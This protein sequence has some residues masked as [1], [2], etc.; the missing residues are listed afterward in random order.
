MTSIIANSGG[1]T[2]ARSAEKND[3]ASS[4]DDERVDGDV[5][6]K[7][8]R[9]RQEAS[10]LVSNA[11]EQRHN[12]VGAHAMFR[13]VS[14]R[15]ERNPDYALAMVESSSPVL[16]SVVEGV[17]LRMRVDKLEG[18]LQA[19]QNILQ[20]L[21][22]H[23]PAQYRDSGTLGLDQSQYPGTVQSTSAMQSPNSSKNNGIS[24]Q[25]NILAASQQ[26]APQ[27]FASYEPESEPS[28]SNESYT[29]SNLPVESSGSDPT[30]AVGAALLHPEESMQEFPPWDLLYSLA[31]LF[32]K[33]INTW[34]PILHR[35]STLD[36]LF[37]SQALDEADRM[38]LH[39]IV[40]TTL[41][42]STDTRVDEDARKRYHDLSK[43][44]V[45]L[46][47]L[48]NSSVKAL[49]ALVILALDIV[50]NSNGPPGW[51]LLALITRSVV[52][53]GLAVETTSAS[54]APLYPSIYTLRAMVLPEPES[55]IE[56]EGRR[57]LFWTVYMLDRYATISTA[58]EFALDDREIDRKLP[59]R[60]DLLSANEAVTTRW[61]Q[62]AG[63]TGLDVDDVKNVG[64]FGYYI[65]ILGIMSHIHRFLKK[66]V[67][68]GALSDVEEWQAEYRQ[69]DH[70][71]SNWK[72][73]LPSDQGNMSRI[74]SSNGSEK[75]ITPLWIMLHITYQTA[76]IR[77]HS[78]AAYPTT[79]SPIF[80]PSFSAAQKCQSAV[81]DIRALSTYV[82]ASNLL[83]QL[84]PPFAFSL[85][86][87]AR[88]LLV[89]SST[90]DHAVSPAIAPLVAILKQMGHYWNVAARYAGLLSRVLDEYAESERAPLTA[91]NNGVREAPSSVRI[92]A[93]MRRTA[94][95]LDFL[96][97]RQPRQKFGGGDKSSVVT[98]ADTKRTP[99]VN[100]LE[101]LDV[102][103]FFNVPRLAFAAGGGDGDLDDG[104]VGGGLDGDVGPGGDLYGGT[105]NGFN[106]QNFL[107]D[108]NSDWFVKNA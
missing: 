8:K 47:G 34:C 44:K 2:S 92:L 5:T 105:G 67:D 98:A 33:H 39:A 22:T 81:E 51:N 11:I 85:W 14:T 27:L 57:R 20:Q 78:S 46:Y 12:V 104:G 91:A 25:H 97:S 38:L 45:L 1:D 16:T 37:G 68:I 19:Q 30:D 70:N 59:C 40:A 83:P 77:L 56:D 65:E 95:D 88:L 89:H 41:R 26:Y 49:Q 10:Q 99:A 103:D 72:F 53:L 4:D 76:I 62:T 71:L 60:D 108:A 3:A 87:A 84:G 15:S 23:L 17:V 24:S 79:R 21:V 7:R 80:T 101:Y 6:R 13:H 86:V 32:F 9:Q 106:I 50:G 74:F 48:E 69:L 64:T 18:T 100:E 82:Q 75:S 42:F 36:S 73:G 90:I 66:P 29:A 107:C 63:R 93:D 31:D 54:V 102:F 43:Q 96:I 94:F 35:K 58:F 52:Q 55:F 28:R 61:F